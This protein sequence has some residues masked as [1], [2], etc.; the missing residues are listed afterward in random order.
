VIGVPIACCF[1]ALIVALFGL[2]LLG[3]EIAFSPKAIYCQAV[4]LSRWF[5]ER[6]DDPTPPLA[7]GLA[8]PRPETTSFIDAR[9]RLRVRS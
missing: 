7:G 2:I 8:M 4:H 3:I 5:S 9:S 6:P 1:T